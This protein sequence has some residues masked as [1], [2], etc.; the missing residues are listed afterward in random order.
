MNGKNV[1][2]ACDKVI[3][4]K[5]QAINHILCFD[6]PKIIKYFSFTIF[7]NMFILMTY[8]IRS[9]I[10]LASESGRILFILEDCQLCVTAPI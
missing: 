1:Y 3:T 9:F 8:I 6:C 2:N 7:K 10:T 5:P 4:F